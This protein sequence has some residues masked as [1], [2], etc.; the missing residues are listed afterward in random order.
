MYS[1]VRILPLCWALLSVC[2]A[3][4]YFSGV[5]PAPEV[6]TPMMLANNPTLTTVALQ[7]PACVFDGAIRRDTAAGATPDYSLYSVTLYGL[8]ATASNNNLSTSDTFQKTS[9]GSLAPFVI[10]KF[11]VPDCSALGGAGASAST[12]QQYLVRVG[13]NTT[14]LNDPNFNGTCNPPLQS[15]TSYRFVYGLLKNGGRIGQTL[16]SDKI[17]TKAVKN[18]DTIDTWPGRRSGG[19]IVITSI[20]SVLLFFLLSGL[21]AAIAAN[22]MGGASAGVQTTRHETTTQQTVPKAQ[23]SA[24]PAYSSVLQGGQPERYAAKP[25]V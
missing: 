14:C 3:I 15:N 21:V 16:W 20:L 19:M 11:A 4:D 10:A 9:G 17:T 24:D 7:R 23:S 2:S 12:L 18:S 8:Q 5:D 13:D 25:Q 6:I 1:F 22:V